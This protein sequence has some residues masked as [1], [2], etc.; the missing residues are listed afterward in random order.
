VERTFTRAQGAAL[1]W[2]G[3]MKLAEK[4]AVRFLHLC[5]CVS[6][7]DPFHTSVWE[8]VPLREI[9][10]LAKP[11][12]HIRRVYKRQR[13]LAI[14]AGARAFPKRDTGANVA[15]K[16]KDPREGLSWGSVPS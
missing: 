15:V 13:A 16:S 12:A 11:K 4:H 8:G 5:I 3:L 7:D 10:W 1:D 9:I 14:K 6:G 2:K